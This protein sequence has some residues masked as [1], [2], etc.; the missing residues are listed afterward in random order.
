LNKPWV[1]RK[2]KSRGATFTALVCVGSALL[3]SGCPEL[4]KATNLNTN[5]T[6]VA[7]STASGSS[8]SVPIHFSE[9]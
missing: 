7:S 4:D 1:A 9:Y 8:G 2:I 3:F 5:K 6:A